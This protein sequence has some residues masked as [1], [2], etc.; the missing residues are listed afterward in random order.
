MIRTSFK[1]RATAIAV[2]SCLSFAPWLAEAASLGKITVLSGLGQPLR[3]EIEISA[4]RAELAGMTARL[5]GSS[6]FKEAG[7]D[8]ASALLDLR[9]DIGKRSN[10]TP[11]VK[12]SSTKPVN[13]PFMDMLVELSWPSGP[14][15]KEYTFLLDPPEVAARAAARQAAATDAR[16]V[17]TVRG[18]GAA[19][20]ASGSAT[21]TASR[22]APEAR[23]TQESGT[24]LVQ[25]GETLRRIAGETKHDGVTLEQML[26]GLY[27]K[28]PDAFI[29]NNVNRLKAGAILSIPDKA[30][31]A[32]IPAAE[33]RQIYVTQAE[34]W[35]AYR[36]KLASATAQGKASPD[37]A[38]P[39]AA[40]GK[41]TARVEEK[42]TAA[43]QA[44]DKVKVSSTEMPAKGVT[45]GKSAVGEEELIAKDKA[46]KEAE[47]RLALLE[48]NVI[49][50]QKL[51]DMKTQ[52]L[53]ELQQQASGQKDETK[54]PVAPAEPPKAVEA[55]KEPAPVAAEPA[56]PVEESKPAEPPKVVEAPKPAAPVEPPKPA[57]VAPPAPEPGLLDDPLPLIGGGGILALL[58]G[59]F[60]LRRRRSEPEPDFTTAIPAPSSLGPNSVFRMTGGQSVDTGNVPLQ[61]GDFSQTGP[62]TI[63]TDEVDPVAEADVYM[64]YGRDAQAEE[65]LIEALRKDPHRTAIHVKLLEIYSNRKS[66][67]QFDT[68]A[69]ELYAQTGGVGDE[70]EKA[71]ALGAALDPENPL[72]TTGRGT[73]AVAGDVVAPTPGAVV[74]AKSTV[75]LPG[76]LGQM[77]AAAAVGAAALVAEQPTLEPIAIP[78]ESAEGDMAQTVVSNIDD[79]A[80]NFDLGGAGPAFAP[81]VTQVGDVVNEMEMPQIEAID[82]DLGGIPQEA[83]TATETNPLVLPTDTLVMS[84]TDSE[85]NFTETIIGLEAPAGLQEE[86]S[87]ADAGTIDF[88]LGD[89]APD[90]QTLVNPSVLHEAT[91]GELGTATIVNSLDSMESVQ[92]EPTVTAGTAGLSINS[93]SRDEEYNVNLSESVFIGNPMPA[94]EFDMTSINLDLGATQVAGLTHVMS[95]ENS[96]ADLGADDV[97]TKLALAKAYE[98]MGDHDQARELLQEVIDEGSGDLVDQARE[99]IGRLRG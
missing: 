5:A 40:G 57:P 42:P 26:V 29:G 18:A 75:V 44:K 97:G 70:W 13:E 92:G 25:Q 7:I 72:Y 50:L 27:K 3:A 66:V 90:T 48:K 79:N 49:E 10:G 35:N 62:G 23:K 64:A 87:E 73:P 77:A 6:A 68:L 33:A 53:A 16:V 28:N 41:V 59:Y 86:S 9:F 96:A 51:V 58:A 43:D 22:A 34:D 60:L 88:E 15:L 47:D 2:A 30:A 98:E 54:P 67:K 8:Y 37:A 99:I 52:R 95:T 83:L 85:T 21:A 94:P 45:G 1:K 63:D 65:I 76:E 12:V 82:F 24:H 91:S 36:Q 84:A 81:E 80:L 69:S 19:P 4:S 46:L 74:D 93:D 78:V 71:A 20:S 14:L 56:K 61:T 55:P 17:E 31:V 32:A 89:I 38:A 39:Q 11:V